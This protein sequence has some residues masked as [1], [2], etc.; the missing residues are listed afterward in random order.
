MKKASKARLTINF[1][2]QKPLKINQTLYIS[3]NVTE[4]GHWNLDN[5]LKM[6]RFGFHFIFSNIR[7][8]DNNWFACLLFSGAKKV[9]LDYKYVIVEDNQN[10]EIAALPLW[11]D[12]DNRS[13]K[14]PSVKSN[15][16]EINAISEIFF[17]KNALPCAFTFFGIPIKSINME[18]S[19]GASDQSAF[20][21]VLIFPKLRRLE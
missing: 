15:S 6:Q 3:G 17:C 19:C 18:M 20:S 14:L 12:G 21:S 5:S 16:K 13:M 8:E 11:E 4:L 2:I 1:T 10:E 7:F 9:F